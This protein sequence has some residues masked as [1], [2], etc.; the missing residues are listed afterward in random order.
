MVARST[1]GS[2][3]GNVLLLSSAALQGSRSRISCVGIAVTAIIPVPDLIITTH[4]VVEGLPVE[5]SDAGAANVYFV[6]LSLWPKQ[7]PIL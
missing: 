6:L 7:E 3:L 4:P 5:N 2:R 1:R